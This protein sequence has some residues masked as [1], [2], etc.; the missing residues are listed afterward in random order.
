MT[1]SN[2][3][4]KTFLKFDIVK[5]CPSITQ[6]ELNKALS[7]SK[8]FS[9]INQNDIDIINHACMNILSD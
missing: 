4:R 9:R 3:I 1:L 8:E 7:L 2:K 6:E 5:F